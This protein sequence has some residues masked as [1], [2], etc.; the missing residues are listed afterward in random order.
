LIAFLTEKSGKEHH[1][2]VES[3]SAAKIDV[4]RQSI[5]YRLH[6]SPF[7]NRAATTGGGISSRD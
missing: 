6:R 1:A 7:T 3:R 2:H 5:S 4:R